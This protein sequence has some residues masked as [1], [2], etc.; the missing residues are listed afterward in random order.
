MPAQTSPDPVIIIAFALVTVFICYQLF[1]L[2]RKIKNHT[3]EQTIK[4]AAKLKKAAKLEKDEALDKFKKVHAAARDHRK[5][6]AK[7][8]KED[9]EKSTEMLRKMMKK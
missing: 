4:S 7:V 6:L 5:K 3:R 9:P 8:I 1:K 2:Y